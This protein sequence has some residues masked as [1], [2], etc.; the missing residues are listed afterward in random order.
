LLAGG[1]DVTSKP[2]L[3]LAEGTRDL[4]F[5]NL[6][7]L[8]LRTSIGGVFQPR[9]TGHECPVYPAIVHWVL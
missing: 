4:T 2:V 1:N 5:G 9:K 6:I 7:I 8:T 3:S